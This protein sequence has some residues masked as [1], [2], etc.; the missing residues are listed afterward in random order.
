V[1][2]RASLD[3]VAKKKIHAPDSR[4][5]NPGSPACSLVTALTELSR[6]P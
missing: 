5:L 4:E 3:A 2:P 6:L 1:G